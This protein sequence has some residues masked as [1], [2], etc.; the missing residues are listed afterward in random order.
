M[1]T[2]IKDFYGKIIGYIEEDSNGNKTVKDFYGRILGYYKKSQNV[3]TDF[4]GRK[5]AQ[6]DQSSM[7]IGLNLNNN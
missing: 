7:L 1:K 5:I 4:Y 6:G 2:P 3:T